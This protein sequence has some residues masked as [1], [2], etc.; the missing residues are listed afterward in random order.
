M[1]PHLELRAPPDNLSGIH[2]EC[3]FYKSSLLDVDII[4]TSMSH[5]AGLHIDD[6]IGSTIIITGAPF[7]SFN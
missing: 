2:H 6:N 1:N 3:T 5:P 7:E 4:D